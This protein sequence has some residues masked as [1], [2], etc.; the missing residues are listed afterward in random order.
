MRDV[1]V[2]EIAGRQHNRFSRAQARACGLSDRE[3]D[4]RIRIG[5]WVAV[6]D[7]VLAIAPVLDHP[8]G[9]WIAATLTAPGT[10]L[11]FTSA[12][13]AWGVWDRPRAL[14]MV[15]RP[16]NGGVRVQD[17]L[18]VHRSET[19]R[20]DVTTVHGIPVTTPGRTLLDVA[21]R[22]SERALARCVRDV[23]RLGLADTPELVGLLVRHRGRRGVRRL[24]EAL[25]RYSG[26][27][28]ERARSGAEVR[29]LEILR[30][31]GAIMPR[32][33]EVVGGEEADLVWRHQR[34][35][36]EIDG[37]PF[38]L[39]RGEDSRKE[40]VWRAEGF[41]VARLPSEAIYEDPV[42]II[43]IAP[44]PASARTSLSPTAAVG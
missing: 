7:G 38:H 8:H 14:E 6:H 41:R 1:Q 23:V 19:L 2:V 11:S 33:N 36:V 37:G 13:A 32:L 20:G 21:P 42:R 29:A 15:T 4:S 44:R 43:V 17:R 27:P 30:D 12:L 24:R 5:R 40:A 31:A 25:E 22:I 28:L 9:R 39:D 10:V 35:I 18:V 34:L 3:I 26:L 16:G